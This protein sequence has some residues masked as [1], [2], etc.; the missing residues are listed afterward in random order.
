MPTTLFEAPPYDP[1]RD[2]RRNTIIVVAVVAVLAVAA[3]GYLFR[4]FPYERVVDRFFTALEQ[5]D[6][7]RAYGIW[8]SDPNWKQ[9]PGKH[10]N[11]SFHDFYVDWGPGGEWGIIREHKI[12]GSAAPKGGSGVVVVVKVNQRAEDARI[13]VERKDK[14]L[15]FSPY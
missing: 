13:W 12:V 1:R 7:E 8:M 6:F 15:T 2:K 9:D 4:N 3:L 5:K 14:T 11:Y 10:A